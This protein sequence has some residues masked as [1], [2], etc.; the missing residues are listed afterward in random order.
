MKDQIEII[1]ALVYLA[2]QTPDSIAKL[3]VLR[4]ASSV[5]YY[6]DVKSG[7]VVPLGLVNNAEYQGRVRWWGGV[8]RLD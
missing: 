3:A 2:E 6:A 1:R 5:L 4:D 7:R 8:A